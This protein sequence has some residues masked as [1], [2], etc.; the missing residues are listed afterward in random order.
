MGLAE[1]LIKLFPLVLVVL[2]IQACASYSGG[3]GYSVYSAS[4]ATT[5]YYGSGDS[6]AGSYFLTPYYPWWS[7]AYYHQYP[8]WRQTYYSPYFYPHYFSFWYPS[9]HFYPY[10][11]WQHAYPRHDYRALTGANSSGF[12]ERLYQ[13]PG[14][15]ANGT[16]QNHYRGYRDSIDS[17]TRSREFRA[18]ATTAAPRTGSYSAAPV[19]SVSDRPVQPAQVPRSSQVSRPERR[20]F[21]AERGRHERNRN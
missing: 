18:P 4:T 8:Y 6:Y 12:Q 11:Y 20:S 13:Q 2:L 1:N 17:V 19:K 16:A 14:N 7:S 9:H 5:E 21:E 15:G 10:P 3:T